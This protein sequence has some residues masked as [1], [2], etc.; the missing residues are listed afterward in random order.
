MQLGKDNMQ[1]SLFAGQVIAML[2]IIPMAMYASAWQWI[3]CLIMYQLI[4]TVGISVGYHRFF[5]HRMF[6]CPTWFEYVMLF[7]ANI[8]MVGPATLWVAN[9]RE[10]HKYVDTDKDPHS[11]THKGYIYSHFLQVFTNPRK[12]FMIDL[13]RDNKFKLQHRFYWEINLVW[14][15]LL[16]LI[17]PFLVIYLWLAPAGISKLLGSLVYSY[18]HRGGKPNTDLWVG[19]VSGGEGFHKPH[20]DTPKLFRWHKY[21]IGGFFIEKCFK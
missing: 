21:D 16:Y 5:S 7:F 9:H 6:K 18:S 11:P 8:M 4:V 19:L 14:G 3:V 15:A 17:D 20:H 10:H 1:R 12:R 2:S 13:L